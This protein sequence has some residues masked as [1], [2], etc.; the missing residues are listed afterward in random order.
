MKHRFTLIELLMVTAVILLL[1]SLLAPSFAKIY[2]YSKTLTSV[3]NLHNISIAQQIYSNNNK[4]LLVL[5][6][7]PVAGAGVG[8]WDLADFL[9]PS[10]GFTWSETTRDASNPIK[11]QIDA[12]N[13]K[14]WICPLDPWNNKVY[15]VHHRSYNANS[16]TSSGWGWGSLTGLHGWGNGPGSTKIA[17]VSNPGQTGSIFEFSLDQILGNSSRAS[18]WNPGDR[19]AKTD[20]GDKP[21]HHVLNYRTPILHADGAALLIY[22]PGTAAN[23]NWFWKAVKP[24]VTP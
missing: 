12:S 10:M 2:R 4:G 13:A 18:S 17:S 6:Y 16:L 21:N 24:E 20:E 11:A 19:I 7:S 3:S 23:D 14:L 5:G 15:P 8:D 22:A 9:A 1:L